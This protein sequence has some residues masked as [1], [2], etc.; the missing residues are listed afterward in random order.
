MD[1]FFLQLAILF[2]PGIIWERIDA[3][4]GLKRP[5]AQFDILRRAF[6]FGLVLYALTYGGYYAIGRPFDFVAPTKDSTFLASSFFDEIIVASILAIVVAIL[7]LYVTRYKLITRLMQTIRATKRFG[8]EDVWDYMFNSNSA[9]VE[10]VHLR[11]FDKRIVYAGW[12][13]VFSETDK[14]RELVLRDV[15]VYSF[16]GPKLFNTPRVYIARAMDKIDIE[17]PHQA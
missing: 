3:L 7:W 17:F 13:E 6:I 16:D 1:I 14:I 5:P 2:L 15:V 8:D 11:D 9:T 12:V 4:Y 10:Y